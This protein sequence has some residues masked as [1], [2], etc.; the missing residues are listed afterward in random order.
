MKLA[1]TQSDDTVVMDMTPMIDVVFQLIIFFM[2]LMD[3]S[4]KDLETLVLPKAKE[5]VED[6]PDPKDPRPVLNILPSGQILVQ[7]EIVYDP[8]NDDAYK[9][10]QEYLFKRAKQMPKAHVDPANPK[11]A[12]AP[13]KPILVRADQSTPFKH[14]QKVM[15]ICGKQDIKIWKIELAASELKTEVPGAPAAGGH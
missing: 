15:E 8:K 10:L 3:M 7:R 14:I 4:Q 2:L 9:K 6:K 1:K 11:S 12:I 13:D 5:A